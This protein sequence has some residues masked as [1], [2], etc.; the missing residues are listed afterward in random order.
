MNKKN[1][2][3]Q[4]RVS[5]DWSEVLKVAGVGTD[6]LTYV[7]GLVGDITEWIY[8]T[9]MLPN[10]MMALGSALAVVGTLIGRKVLGPT[11]SMTHLC[12]VFLAPS[13]DG[14]D[15]PLQRGRDLVKA[16]VGKDERLIIGDSTWQSAPGIEMMLDEC[17]VRVCFIDEVG[18]E[19]KKINTQG[20]NTWVA[21]TSGLLKK[22]YNARGDIRTGRT[23]HQS[24]VTIYDAAMTLVCAATPQKFW[25][26]F[27]TNDL[28][29]GVINRYIVLPVM[30]TTSDKIQIIP[31]EAT[32][33]PGWLVEE[34][35]KLPR[36][37]MKDLLDQKPAEAGVRWPKV[38]DWDH[39]RWESKEAEEIWLAAAYA[40]RAEENEKKKMIGKRG[41]ENAVRMAEIIAAGCF[42]REVSTQDIGWGLA[43]A[44]RSVEVSFEGAEKFLSD[45]LYFP[46]MCREVHQ[47]II[48]AGGFASDRSL[49]RELGRKD[50]FGNGLLGRAIGQLKLEGRIKYAKRS[51]KGRPSEGWELIREEGE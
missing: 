48:S 49:Q 21:N 39:Q 23:K 13:G 44:R 4:P 24:G 12:I 37:R 46:D 28:E 45:F 19:L 20:G 14:K 32:N 26:G 9:S 5:R 40:F 34:L 36:C 33:P 35:K 3:A 22:V 10:R 8:E 42:R 16:V 17:P 2:A 25:G 30:D 38:E 43:V 29:S 18:D 51:G 11:G 41:A 31:Y 47:Y 1:Y 7:P 27:G 6:R 15:D 50:R